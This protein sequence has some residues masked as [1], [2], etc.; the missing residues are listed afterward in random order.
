MVAHASVKTPTALADLFLEA[1]EA[2]DAILD[3]IGQRI[4]A[5]AGRVM[6]REELRLGGAES[7]M[8]RALQGRLSAL[9]M[10]LQKSLGRISRGL[11]LKHGQV[12]AV[13]DAA[14]RRIQFAALSRVSAEYSKLALKE[15]LVRASDPRNILAMGYVLV[16]GKD[17]KVLKTVDKV[18]V[19]DR[20]GVRFSDG[21]LTAKVDEIYS[22]TSDNHKLN[23]A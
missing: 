5:A 18:A 17:N 21:S 10:R 6:S 23:I 14:Q 22:E 2:Q 3:R 16:T 7:R 1:Y 12:A 9:E 20:I 13:K 19:G 15:A 4:M 8:H 11:L